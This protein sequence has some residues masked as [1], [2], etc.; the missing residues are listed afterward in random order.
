MAKVGDFMY[1]WEPDPNDKGPKPQEYSRA[2]RREMAKIAYKIYKKTAKEMARKGQL[3]DG[4][5]I[6]SIKT[7]DNAQYDN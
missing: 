2:E 5:E 3:K 4:M 7:D 6:K 1:G